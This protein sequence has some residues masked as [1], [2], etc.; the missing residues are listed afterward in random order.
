MFI[1]LQEKS[2]FD[3]LLYIIP[4]YYK[5][6]CIAWGG[7]NNNVLEPLQKLQGRKIKTI[8]RRNINVTPPPISY[9]FLLM[10][11]KINKIVKII[12]RL[13]LSSNSIYYQ[14]LKKN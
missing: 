12:I 14:T 13:L 3:Y 7:T 6:W 8:R 11:S 1:I 10:N 9:Q 5:I 4:Q 2:L